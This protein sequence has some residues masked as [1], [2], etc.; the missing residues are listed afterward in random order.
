MSDGTFVGSD[1]YNG[2]CPYC[3]SAIRTHLLIRGGYRLRQKSAPQY[4]PWFKRM[5]YCEAEVEY[6]VPEGIDK[7]KLVHSKR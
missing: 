5:F 2:V 3:G 6:S 4:L 1:I 7:D